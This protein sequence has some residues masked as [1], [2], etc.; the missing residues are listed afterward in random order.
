MNESYLIGNQLGDQY[1]HVV[2]K[3]F[4]NSKDGMGIS[5]APPGSFDL[6]FSDNGG[7]ARQKRIEQ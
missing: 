7:D 4:R 2:L 1:V 5:V 3:H 6:L